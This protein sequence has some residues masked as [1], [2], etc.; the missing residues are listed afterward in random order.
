MMSLKNG[1]DWFKLRLVRQMKNLFNLKTVLILLLF[2]S[3][4]VN[5]QLYAQNAD[6]KKQVT[7]F[8]EEPTIKAKE[9]VRELVKRL[10]ALVIL[11][12]GEDPVIATVTD[13]DKLK[14]QP[15]FAK[16]ENGD[17]LI[18]YAGEKKAYLF[19]EKNNKVRDIIPVNIGEVAGAS[20]SAV[21]KVTAAPKANP[22][23]N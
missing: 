20:A 3:F 9:E 21:P 8:K 14:D 11:P 18:I 2:F 23:P 5:R 22:E 6:L 7:A 15:V 17:K 19:D 4:L 10:S 13:K 1:K 12:E 16:A